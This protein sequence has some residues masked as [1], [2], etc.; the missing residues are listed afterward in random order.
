M[1]DGTFAALLSLRK[2]L[3]FAAGRKSLITEWSEQLECADVSSSWVDS[4]RRD[5]YDE[6]R[7]ERLGTFR[8]LTRCGT[9][10]DILVG[11]LSR[12]ECALRGSSAHAWHHRD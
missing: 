1:E 2:P 12:D 4:L 6:P 7:L 9:L 10:L 11:R 8:E 5:S 3:A